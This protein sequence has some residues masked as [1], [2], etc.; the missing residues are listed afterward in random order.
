M[1]SPIG[2]FSGLSSGIQWQDL[3]D[4]IMTLE[5]QRR[6]TPLTTQ[7]SLEQKRY[8]AWG[9]WQSLAA[10]F[11]DATAAVRDSTAFSQ[12]K[13]TGGTSD[14]TGRTLLSAS[15]SASASP[16]T[17]GVEVLDL[18]RANKLS[19][20]VKSSATTALGITG[21]FGVNG[22]KVTISAT[23]T[24][25]TLRDRINGL[26]TGA[27][28]TGIT[29]SVLSTG[30][31]QHRLVL[32]ATRTGASGI[33]LVDDAAGTLQS[34]GFTDATRTLNLDSAGGAQSFKVSSSTQ[35]I[36]AMLGV[37]M[38]APSTITIGGRTVSV[39]LTVDSLS[40]I[41]AKIM[42]AGG[43][44]AVVT[45]TVDGVTGYRLTT[46]DT[47]TAGSVDGQRTLDVLGFMKGGRSGVAQTLSS[48]NTF[49][50]ASNATATAATLLTG[51]QVAGNPLAIASGDTFT[52]QG[53]RGD[54]SIVNLSFVVGAGDTMQTLV[55]KINDAT[56]GYGAGTRT[57]TASIVGGQLV[58]NDNTTGDSQLSL[59]MS[60]S[61]VSGGTVSLG[62]VSATTIGRQREVVAGGDA[63]VAVDGVVIRRSSNT[64]SDALAGVTLNLQQ[65]EVG[66]VTS[67]TIGRDDDAVL[68]SIGDVA[69][70]YNEMLKFRASQA[71][72]GAALFNNTTLRAS[73]ASLTNSILSPVLGGANG[74]TQASMAGLSLQRDG[75][76]LLDAGMFK[77]AMA[78]NVIDVTTLFA[79][80]GSAT[81]SAV[82]Y[83]VSTDRTIPGTY[84]VDITSAAT[85]PTVSGASF[86]GT[87]VDDGTADTMSVTDSATGVTTSVQLANG[88]TIDTI[89]A[90]LNA[91]FSTDKQS[92][93]ASKN[94]NN[95]VL[96]GSQYGTSSTITTAYTAGGADGTA[97]L[98][99]AAGIVTGTD[100]AGT[101]GGLLATGSGQTLTGVVGGPTEGLS[102]RY[103]GATVGNQGTVTF[104]LGVSGA[105]YNAADIISRAGGTVNTQQDSLS[106]RVTDLQ[107]RADTVTQS[108]ERR[109]TSLTRQFI[110]METALSRIQ[111]QGSAITGYLSALNQ[112][113]R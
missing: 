46:N 104:V 87:Y 55:D 21:E 69:A 106:K 44:A 73:M 62:R 43:T 68:K 89:V 81:N 54:G 18:A 24:L 70:A 59:A 25:S 51:M 19:G 32:T 102:L 38:P 3:V 31:N 64:I 13:T 98:G 45:E 99:I 92:I 40:S 42:S 85:I 65:S 12:F 111:S 105:L 48:D 17:F 75:T 100:V 36:A 72:V 76:L 28:A 96:T 63:R 83:N 20:A 53:A 77:A 86:S 61:Q 90:R 108:L 37:T 26:N 11:R 95:L 29:A 110:A 113:N 84:A 57:A 33:E 93:T 14:V 15:A 22:K 39:D 60:V 103:S 7:K 49:T 101:I 78:S 112:Q 6:L 10:K 16:G 8:D 34:L 41:A 5:S 66:T 107:T 67:L 94:G 52:L 27:N 35:A 97:Q 109:R 91:A 9:S 1:S 58:L 30:S 47:V 71:V 50:D 82:S 4:Q 88:D 56:S 74:F 2:S 79:N 23:D 80:S